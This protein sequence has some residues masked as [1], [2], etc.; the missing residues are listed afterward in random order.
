M[1]CWGSS[2]SSMRVPCS[3]CCHAN[4]IN[5]PIRVK[6][7]PSVVGYI[8]VNCSAKVGGTSSNS[9]YSGCTISNPWGPGLSSPK[10]RT[11]RPLVKLFAWW[12]WKCINRRPRLAPFW[13][14]LTRKLTR[15]PRCRDELVICPSTKQA[16]LGLRAC[17]G[18]R[19]VRSW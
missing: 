15:R 13:L 5:C 10:Q 12:A 3:S 18:T 16:I 9:T 8:G 4:A 7:R 17:S 14:I 1:S 11:L 6:L 19:R 2:S